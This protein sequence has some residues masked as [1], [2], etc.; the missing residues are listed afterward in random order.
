M[1]TTGLE[2]FDT[3]IQKTNEWLNGIMDELGCD[4]H[5]AY[6]ALRAVLHALRDRLTVEESAQLAAQLPTLIRGFYY[7]GWTPAGKP[8]R[9]HEW[10]F[11]HAI[12]ASFSV[13]PERPDPKLVAR[14]VLTV[15]SRHVSQG[16]VEDVIAILPK[17][18]QA[19]WPR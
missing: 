19:L 12:Q 8:R 5:M 18:L 7:E 2:V 16:E 3:I 10:E 11:L 17:D 9:T 14:A 6:L 15:L 4:R 13:S 1:T